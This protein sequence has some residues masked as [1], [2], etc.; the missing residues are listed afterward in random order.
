M[1]NRDFDARS[2]RRDL[3]RVKDKD[4]M[5]TVEEVF[6]AKTL[7]TL[8]DL[9][10]KRIIY[11]MNG[12]ISSGKESRVYLAY[13][14]GGEQYAVKIYLTSSAI[15][16]KGIMKYIAGDPR[17]SGFKPSDT[18]K[19]IYAWAR[20]EFSNLSRMYRAGV[21][22]PR[23]ISFRNNVV[24]MEFAGESGKRYP[25]LVEAYGELDREDLAKIYELVVEEYTKIVCK[26]E[27]VHADFS[28]YN[29]MVKPSVD[30]VVIDVSQAVDL[31]HPK[32]YD[33]LA[34]DV[35]NITRFFRNAANIDS[36]PSSEELIERIKPCLERRV[37]SS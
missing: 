37:A 4:L 33:F 6:D 31:R 8:Y 15:F 36:I 11:K 18:R 3:K 32:S 5:E 28:E 19:L 13:G 30:I 1:I 10:K 9:M 29:V 23:P 14:Y 26:A 17:F 7:L 25:L 12:V 35:N 2:S 20:K 27:L 34:R 24:V 22:V 16:R 21:K